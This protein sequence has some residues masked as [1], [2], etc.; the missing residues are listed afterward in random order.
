MKYQFQLAHPAQVAADCVVVGVYSHSQLSNAAAQLDS[1]SN[2]ALSKH[3]EYGDFT[4]EKGRVSLLYELAQ[5]KAKR[6]LLV[7]L[8]E[9]EKLNSDVITQATQQAV[10]RLK[11]TDAVNV[12]SFL[13]ELATPEHRPP[14]VRAAVMSVAEALYTFNTY[15]S[16]KDDNP[17]KLATWTLA[18]TDGQDYAQA[19]Q[20]GEAIAQG[21]ALTRDLG[22][23]PGNVCTPTYLAETAKAL[24]DANSRLEIN[25]L[26]EEAMK[27]LGMNSFLSVS[28]GSD[29]PGKMAFIHYRGTAETE[30]P[31]VL[32]GK[33][34]TFDTG[35]ISLKPGLN[36]DEMKYDMCGAATVLGVLQA[37][38]AMNLA[39]NV[40]GVVV[41]AENM[42]SG[43]ASKPGDIVTSMSG[44]TIEILNTD[45]EGRLV[46]CDALTYVERFNPAAVVD[47]AT[48]TGACITAL[49]HHTSG[50]MSNNDALANELLEAG[51]QAS[52]EA[53][54]LPLGEKYQE[55]LKSNFADMANIGGPAGGAITAACFLA[56]FTEN[57]P[58]AHL[59]IAGTAWKTG[60]AKGASARPVPLLCQ[61]LLNRANA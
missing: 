25:V 38:A 58:W 44:K 14:V 57:Y 60:A 23:T 1:A 46:L 41:A 56:R 54:R 24:A 21:Q 42:P 35:G 13:T 52:D 22:N 28:K 49:G 47:I 36:M 32:V 48:L 43:K 2:Q 39:L 59:D 6:V 45:A 33:G 7:G 26:D 3:C 40:I 53:W 50:L 29:Q 17:P 4:G 27:T 18:H 15:K 11:L 8:G 12:V 34:I 9:R 30:Q 37:C 19:L 16:A 5:V 10:N 55:Q 51:K 20:Q 61:W 31:L